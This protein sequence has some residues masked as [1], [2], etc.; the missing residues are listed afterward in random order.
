MLNCTPLANLKITEV[1]QVIQSMHCYRRNL[2]FSEKIVFDIAFKNILNNVRLA[3]MDGMQ[4]K[5]IIDALNW[6]ALKLANLGYTKQFIHYRC[7][8]GKVVASLR[9]FQEENGPKIENAAHVG[10]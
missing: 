7:L 3:K 2:K 9:E 6:K 1:G 4:M 10:A 5:S 8:S